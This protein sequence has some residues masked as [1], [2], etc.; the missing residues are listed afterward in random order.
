MESAEGNSLTGIHRE[1]RQPIM[2]ILGLVFIASSA[3]NP[4][5]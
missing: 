3:V 5:F 1:K 2:I 4:S